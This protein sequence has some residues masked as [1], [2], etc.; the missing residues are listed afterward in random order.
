MNHLTS[1]SDLSD[2]TW[3][4]CLARAAHFRETREWTSGARGKS[5]ALLFLN[6]SLRTRASMEL[7]AQHL[8]AVPVTIT[9]GQGTWGLAWGEDA[10]TGDAAEHVHEAIGVLARYADAIGVRTFASLTDHDADQSDAALAA[11]VEASGVPVVNLESAKWHPC[12]ELGDAAAITETLGDPR[13][14]KL[15]L[16]WAPHPKALPQAVPNS[17]LLMAARL[18]MEVVVARPDG[19]GLASG[20]M[21]LAQQTAARI[22]RQ[23]DRIGRSGGL[24]LGR[25]HRLREGVE[26]RAR[27][28]QPGRGIAPEAGPHGRLAHHQPPHDADRQRPLHAL[29]PRPPRRGRGRR[30]AGVRG[31]H[32]PPPG[33][34]PAPRAESDSGVGLG[35]RREGA[36]GKWEGQMIPSSPVPL[37]ASLS[38]IKL[39]GAVAASPEA[40]ASLWREVA[41]I[42]GPVVVVHGGGPQATALAR[43]LGHEPRI[44]AGR[45][46]T[47]DLDLDVALYVMRGSV[48]ARLVGSASGARGG[49]RAVGI[50]GADGGLVGVVKRPPRVIDGETVDFGHV[51]DVIGV[52]PALPLALLGAGFTPVVA[53]I[54]ADRE[55]ALYNVNADTVALELAVALGAARLILVAEASGVRRDATDPATLISHLTP[56]AIAAGRGGR[57]DRGRDAAQARSRAR[58]PLA[59]RPRSPRDRAGCHLGPRQ[60]HHH[61]AGGHAMSTLSH[62]C[63]PE[64]S[65]Q[66]A[67]EGSLPSTAFQAALSPL[68]GTCVAPEI[69]RLAVLAQDDTL[70]RPHHYPPEA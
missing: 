35:P 33:R 23:R 37:P 28:R 57:L 27:L 19:F 29:P 61:R 9:P 22:R 2:E 52:D 69:L 43:Q 56:E 45:R 60:R 5:I 58:G 13:G 46:V 59:R 16:S 55:G 24:V 67:A 51:G 11:I 4:A 30:G 63:H 64:R 6:P 34:V 32:P 48:N 18:G 21:D 17:A 8:G 54:C 41:A 36:R 7:A 62:P 25:R 20:V 10:M 40:C 42:G 38:V 3:Q 39:G 50:S 26:R 66:G 53:S 14:K 31:R 49:I 1:W 65:P 15:V 68:A 70:D 47:S 12:Q 44:V